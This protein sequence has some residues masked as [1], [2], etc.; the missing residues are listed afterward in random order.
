ME[1]EPVLSWMEVYDLIMGY[2]QGTQEDV[3]KAIES[4]LAYYQEKL[5]QLHKAQPI[6]Q[7]QII[8]QSGELKN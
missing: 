2:K 8:N 3:L 1:S 4:Y 5:I 6:P 7:F